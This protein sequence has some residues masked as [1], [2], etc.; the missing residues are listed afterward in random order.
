LVKRYVVEKGSTW[1]N[2]LSANQ[3][4]VSTVVYAEVASAVA[5]RARGGTL[6]LSDQT[7]ILNLFRY[8][9]IHLFWKIEVDNAVCQ[10]A[11]FLAEKY[12]LR[13]YDS[14]Q[15]AS[16][17][18]AELLFKQSGVPTLTFLTSDKELLVAGS[19]AGL[20]MDDPQNYP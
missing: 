13:A 17:I 15:L 6:S 2:G 5:R 7:S 10:Q 18:R 11:G 19:Q 3:F 8:E 20:I 1:L 16:A 4:V 12:V 9:M 14:L